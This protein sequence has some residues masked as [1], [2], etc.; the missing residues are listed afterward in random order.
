M[1]I[2]FSFRQKNLNF[3]NESMKHTYKKHKKSHWKAICHREK[4][5]NC[6]LTKKKSTGVIVQNRNSVFIK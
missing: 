4:V 6:Y 1:K 3:H 5:A 2:R